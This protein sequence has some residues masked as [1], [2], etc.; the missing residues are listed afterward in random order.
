M[1]G[2][3]IADKARGLYARFFPGA[4]E[5]KG[6]DVL[7]GHCPAA[8]AHGHG[9]APTDARIYLTY[10]PKGQPP[11][12]YCLH[13][14]CKGRLE[15]MNDEFR[16]ELF[17]KDGKGGGGTPPEEGVVIRA[18]RAREGWIPEFSIAKLR[19]L[20]AGVPE[21]GMDWFAARSPVKPE[22]VMGPG[23]F[24][25]RVF[26]PGERVLVCTEFKGPGD[27]LWQVGKGGYRLAGSPGV[28]AVPSKLP[29]QCGK[30]GAW[31][32]ANPVDGQWYPNP[33]RDGR[34]SRRSQE[35]VTTWKHLILESDEAKT[36]RKR[37]LLLMYA[38]AAK[39]GPEA[40][41]KEAKADPKWVAAMLPLQAEWSA[42]ATRMR[43]DA[44]EVPGLWLRLLAMCG[45]PI[46]AIYTS[47]GDSVHALV[48]E[49][50]GSW[51][52]F[53]DIVRQ[54]KGRLPLV[55]ADPGALT[56][57]R[58]TRLPGCTRGGQMQR[59]IYLDPESRAEPI[60]GR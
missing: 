1:A 41:L 28:K 17:R 44:L 43:Q 18:P 5:D 54:Y 30:E 35:S 56:P 27:Y 15:A 19:G 33:R 21:V 16:S 24:L 11:G 50:R 42:M 34:P 23:D 39:C 36:L 37:A 26:D 14:S 20:V 53:S 58:L 59:L 55:G 45:L 40:Y 9:S 38:R 52:E 3:W 51:A 10:G 47:G 8:E 46:A 29:V 25:E 13:S 4:W 7:Q 32:L 22:T 12:V 31:F 49:P 57:V 48:R 6:G 2:E 60:L